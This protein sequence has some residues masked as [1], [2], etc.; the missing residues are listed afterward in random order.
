MS[1]SDQHQFKDRYMLRLP[2]GMRDDIKRLAE[3]NHRS[4]NAEIVAALEMHLYASGGPD[5]EYSDYERKVSD[6]SVIV[7]ALQTA[8]RLLIEQEGA[9]IEKAGKVV[10]GWNS[11][12]P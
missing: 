3:T 5:R 2:D 9:D 7:A 4:M 12:D 10:E 1:D 11:D 6:L 8:K